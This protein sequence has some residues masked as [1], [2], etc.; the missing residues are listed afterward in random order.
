MLLNVELSSVGNLCFSAFSFIN[1]LKE[2]IQILLESGE[3]GWWRR[4]ATELN[5]FLKWELA[6]ISVQTKLKQFAAGECK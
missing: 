4:R 1:D 3:R 6:N 2:N 5:Y